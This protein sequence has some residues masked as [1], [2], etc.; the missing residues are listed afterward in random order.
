[1]SPKKKLV[2]NKMGG[3]Q[4][5]VGQETNDARRV[6][7][8]LKMQNKVLMRTR[9]ET[10]AIL[11]E[12]E[13]LY[14]FAPLSYFSLS[15]EGTIRNANLTGAGLLEFERTGL[16]GQNFRRFISTGS[17]ANFDSFL[18]KIF[19]THN[20]ESCEVNLEREGVEP[21]SVRIEAAF[22][23]ALYAEG[24]CHF[25]V[26]DISEHRR[27]G[28]ISQARIRIT[29]FAEDHP[30]GDLLQKALDE[31]CALTNS[32]IGFFHFVEPD[33]KTLSLQAW[34][35]HTLLEMCT[36]EG[37]GRHY[38]IDQAGVWVDCVRERRPIIHNDYAALPASSK[39]GMPEGHA[40]VIRE[41]IFPIIRNQKIVAVIGVGNKL[42]NY[43]EDDLAYALRLADLIWDITERKR[44]EEA[45]RESEA[46]YRSI[47][48]DQTEL[49]CR[50][51]PDGRLSYV[52]EA[53]ARY[54]GQT[55]QTLINT[56]FLPH[57]P[58]PDI[59]MVVDRIAK[60][61]PQEPVVVYEHRV[62]NSN[63]EIR[64][65]NW[66]HR[67][68]YDST[69][70]LV[71]HQAVGRDIT[72]RKNAEEALREGEERFRYV[73]ENVQDAVW[74]A[75]LTGQFIFL[76]PVMER[77]YE[78]PLEKMLANPDFWIEVGHPDDQAALR[79]SSDILFREK[80]V[81]L[82]YRII[83]PNGSVR[84]ISDRKFLLQEDSDQ[85]AQM[86]GVVSD[87]TVRK[88]MENALATERRRLADI[89][90]GTNAG[91]WEWNIQ[92]GKTIF[93]ERWAEIVGYTLEELAPV[94]IETWMKLAHPDDLKRSG[95]LMEMH[96]KG[97]LDYY[98]FETRMRHKNGDW[99]WV[100]DRGKVTTWTED[101]KPL[102]MSGTHQDITPHKQA[103]E[104][105][106]LLA[107]F[108]AEDPNPVLRVAQNGALLYINEAGL[109]LLPEWNLVIGRAVPNT[110]CD[111]V[112][113]SMQ[114]GLTQTF[115]LEHKDHLYAFYVA[116]IISSGYA[117]I[118]GHDIT[119]STQVRA[120][121]DAETRYHVLFDQS[122]YGI[123]LVDPETGCTLE[124]NEL[125][126]RQLG[127]TPQEF[128][129]L[130][131]SDY[132]AL[133][134]PDQVALHMQKIIDEDSDDFET[135]HRTRT[136]ELRNVHVWVKKLVLNG[137]LFFYT[138]Y[139]DIT[140]RK[141]MEDANE[142]FRREIVLLEERQ[143][144]ASDLHDA[145]SQ[146]L[147]SAR[148]TTETL[149]RQE[150]RL[151][152]LFTRSLMDLNRLVRS[153]SAEIRLIFG[154]LRKNALLTVSLN[155]LLTNLIDSGM[156]RT[157]AGFV[158]QNYADQFDLPVQVKLAFYRIAQEAISN[159]IK[160]G[161]PATISCILREKDT[162]I[163][164][165]V[166]QDDGIGFFVDKVSDDHFGLQIM[167]E[168]ADLAGVNLTLSSQPGRGTTVTVCWQ[169]VGS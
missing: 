118:Y 159:A 57:I 41:M 75:N 95:E 55:A 50:Y 9:G 81:A 142:D 155:T 96:F 79:A 4:P 151:S 86:V 108:P 43:T 30:L 164:E 67:G 109:K 14:D 94:S 90:K 93:N 48:E 26:S 160:H 61:T 45:L 100:I 31:L 21:V 69:G 140:E 125:A 92:T 60:I 17:Y 10:Q 76:S 117:N 168:R 2:S 135:L 129:T 82:E 156:A 1:M 131:I 152:E 98:E 6:I 110:L 141:R 147:F 80:R 166:I 3:Q 18:E 91:T 38:D 40:P 165:M 122:P 24:V 158:L 150:D 128:I 20:K 114:D 25:V 133:E 154:E 102:Q 83:R 44:A 138:T 64:W 63:D 84:W 72:E 28:N 49:I 106:Q 126:S 73:L 29:E 113:R 101:G 47:L 139:Q 7:K 119:E 51:L 56:N 145:V 161:K 27:A 58:E 99:V 87:I 36:A 130:K 42:G 116:P 137:R 153:A 169:E 89:L 120:L 136:G 121:R 52:N 157:N 19:S 143:R 35:T 85:P 127:Y 105:I 148:L 23:A 167:R 34:S 5:P 13:D 111:A 78:L 32:P 59:S 103:E 163:L 77:I 68:I 71:E 54:Y 104:Q 74:S 146:T 12:Y 162:K 107:K 144:I 88:Q 134:D 39:K 33:Q 97:E 46:R 22:S 112:F 123:L 124:S 66:T 15:R 115:D 11:R 70:N 65:Q 8:E 62:I 37:K 53:Y 16:I 149:L 132:E